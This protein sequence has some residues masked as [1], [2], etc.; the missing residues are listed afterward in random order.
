LIVCGTRNADATRLGDPFKAC[1]DI[2]AI[3][4]DIAIVNDNVADVNADAE[5]NPLVLR[6]RG[7]LLGHAALNVNGATYRIHGA[8]KFDQHA[9]TGRFDDAASMGS[10]R[11]INEGLSN[12]LKPSQR[13]LLVGTHQAAIPGDIRR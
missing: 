3:A 12:S 13:N 6:H 11:G 8:S 10:Y 2:D 1:R 7:I 9:V 4:E 5:F